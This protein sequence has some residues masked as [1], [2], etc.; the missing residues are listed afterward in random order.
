MVIIMSEYDERDQQFDA[1]LKSVGPDLPEPTAS[2][3]LKDRVHAM[4]DAAD[5][6]THAVVTDATPPMSA[7]VHIPRNEAPP[8]LGRLKWLTA[9]LAACVAVMGTANIFQWSEMRQLHTTITSMQ[10]NDR[11]SSTMAFNTTVKSRHDM[12][13]PCDARGDT[14]QNSPGV[15]RPGQIQLV[16]DGGD[17]QQRGN[18]IARGDA[19]NHPCAC[20][21][22]P[23]DPTKKRCLS[24][25]R[26]VLVNLFHELC[27]RSRMMKPLFEQFAEGHKDDP[28]LFCITLDITGSHLRDAITHASMLG[29]GCAFEDKPGFESGMIKIIDKDESAVIARTAT[30]EGLSDLDRI[31]MQLRSSAE[32]SPP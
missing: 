19:T 4:L 18:A 23:C 22:K 12:V 14:R 28:D 8:A 17:T 13:K 9:A 30:V 27:P 25:P 5:A 10:T 29:V 21:G 6:T 31:I 3:A 2:E 24:D 16:T 7:N 20:V 1:F 26:F 15:R 32:T 11:D